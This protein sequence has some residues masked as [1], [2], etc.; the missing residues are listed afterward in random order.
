MHNSI[1]FYKSSRLWLGIIW[2]ATREIKTE[3]DPDTRLQLV[4]RENTIVL[5]DWISRTRIV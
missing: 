2:Q 4:Y 3:C 5:I 1:R